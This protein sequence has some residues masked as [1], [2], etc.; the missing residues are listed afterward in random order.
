MRLPILNLSAL[1]KSFTAPHVLDSPASA[2]V[3][4]RNTDVL[5]GRAFQI[6]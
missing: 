2:D 6:V 5:K 3:V 1:C 4:D